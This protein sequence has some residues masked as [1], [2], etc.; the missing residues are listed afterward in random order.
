MQ[1]LELYNQDVKHAL[2]DYA[3]ARQVSEGAQFLSRLVGTFSATPSDQCRTPER[4]ADHG[5]L[6]FFQPASLQHLFVALFT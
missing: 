4:R 6:L 5:L 2:V 3:E 1:E